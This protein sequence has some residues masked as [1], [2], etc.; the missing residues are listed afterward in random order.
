[1]PTSLDDQKYYEWDGLAEN[2]ISKWDSYDQDFPT[3]PYKGNVS[4]GGTEPVATWIL[5]EIFGLTVGDT[6][7]TQS[8]VTNTLPGYDI[9][10]RE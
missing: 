10:N 8:P 7:P 4:V 3:Q 5:E 9:K 6:L 2:W 1:M